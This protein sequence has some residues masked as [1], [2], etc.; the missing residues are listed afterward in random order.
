MTRMQWTWKTKR[1]L[2]PVAVLLIALV[3]GCGEEKPTPTPLTLLE[4]TQSA[5]RAQ[6]LGTVTLRVTAR[7]A[8]SRS[9]RFSWEASA[10]TLGTPSETENTSEVTWT[11]PACSERGTGDVSVSVTASD[12]QGGSASTSFSLS[13]LGC[14]TLAIASGYTHSLARLSDGTVWAWGHNQSGQLGD[15]TTTAARAT[16]VQVSGLTGV[17]AMTAG[18]G[19]SLA[20]RQDGTVWAWGS[21][22]S[23][24][25]GDGTT[26]SRSS[27]VQVSGLTGVTA[28]ATGV[29]HSLAV[30][31]DGTLWA[32]GSNGS[33]ELGDGTTTSRSFPVQVSGL[34]G[35]TTV[36]AGFRHAL[37][38]R[39]DGTVWAWGVNDYGQLGDGSTTS[40]SSPVQ[41]AGLTGVIAVAAS[42]NHSLA[43]RQDGTVWAWGH[44]APVGT[45]GDA[46]NPSVVSTP[47]QVSG[48]TG[49]TAVAAGV[50]HS[51]VLRQDGTLWGWGDNSL[52]Q[53]G[54][55]PSTSRSTPFQ[56]PGL[57]GVTALASGSQH[58]L[59]LLDDGTVQ[60][61]GANAVGQ[62]GNG[63]TTHRFTPVQVPALTGVTALLAGN[64]HSLA[65]RQDGTPWAWGGNSQ[66]QLGD[67]TTSSRLT[68]AQVPGL[69][70]VTALAG[71]G[72]HTL[73]L[74]Q[75]GTVWAWGYNFYGQLGD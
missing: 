15:G 27:P 45:P 38:V 59:A 39:Q 23:G 56:V 29:G 49:A 11:A 57:T 54:E 67:G 24:Q 14:R 72:D 26:T 34:T 75:D 35:L 51:L 63:K 31:Q 40:R 50:N 9:L 32:W 5:T 2:G 71:S 66:G 3:V 13:L 48:L 12:E 46:S 74:R 33:G 73:A 43:V 70:G 8:G 52:G 19:C 44:A 47:V 30:R 18:S 4:S 65:L 25:L 64:Q 69:T 68:P 7:D 36:A 61:L 20:V 58:T 1:F 10:G 55:G 17:T 62:L 37:A 6:A 60:A 16:P 41:V 28:L 21:N 42:A 22:G 53:L